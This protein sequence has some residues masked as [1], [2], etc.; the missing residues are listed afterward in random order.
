MAKQHYC[1]QCDTFN[2]IEDQICPKCGEVQELI[3]YRDK[4]VAVVLA[5]IGGGIG[6]H[7]F[8]LRR[9]AEGFFYILFSMT[10]IPWFIAI[11]EG[12]IYFFTEQ[13]KWDAKYNHG[14]HN[15]PKKKTS[16]KQILA[17]IFIVIVIFGLMASV[18]LPVYT[19]MQLRARVS[20]AFSEAVNKLQPVIEDYYA[21]NK[22][23]PNHLDDIDSISEIAF[24]D[25]GGCRIEKGGQIK[26]WFDI[27]PELK[28]IEIFLKPYKISNEDKAVLWSCNVTAPDK[29][30]VNGFLPTICKI[31]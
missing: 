20:Y 31:K 3:N 5:I 9:W 18:A 15:E 24:P 23:F 17:E 4:T 7:K 1:K 30:S 19:T 28:V 13:Q 21:I 6:L 11:I 27:L 26:I 2:S 29:V 12:I 25:G 8:Y 16:K 14:P 22:Q 10:F